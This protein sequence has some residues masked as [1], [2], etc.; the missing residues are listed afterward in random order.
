MSEIKNC[1]CGK[2]PRVV[3]RSAD[4]RWYI[5]CYAL[6][7]GCGTSTLR[8]PSQEEAVLQW[9]SWV[10]S[11]HGRCLSTKNNL[12]Y[13]LNAKNV[14][15]EGKVDMNLLLV[16]MAEAVYE[17]CEVMTHGAV[18]HEPTGWKKVADGVSA[19]TNALHRH[20]NAEAR[21]E[22]IDPEFGKHHAAHAAASALI[23]LQL[24][25]DAEKAQKEE[26]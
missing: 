20:L 3:F 12:A 21:G 13:G 9:N 11:F 7:G 5:E 22:T 10:D 16:D 14:M 1:T 8:Y 4:G 18:K 24:I 15:G 25:I 26:K 19:Y 2:E 6:A 23:R 17:V